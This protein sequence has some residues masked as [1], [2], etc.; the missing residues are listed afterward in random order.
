M[1]FR[2][3]ENRANVAALARG[4]RLLDV[5]C[6]S[7]GFAITAAVAGARE[8]HAIDRSEPALALAGEAAAMNGVA[9]RCKF[10]RGDAFESLDRLG[11]AGERYDIVVADPPAFVKSKKDIGAGSRAYR[12]LARLAASCV[13]PGGFLFIASCSH[14]MEAGAFAEEVRRG[15]QDAARGGRILRSSGAAPDHPVHPHL[16]ESAYLKALLL[17]LD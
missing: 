6:Y 17:Q 8:I 5:Y 3:R 12:K 14:N 15:L 10:E 4:Q 13:A 7:G 9:E 16:P 1:L 2:S 11:S